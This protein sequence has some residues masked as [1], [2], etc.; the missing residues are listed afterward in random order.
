[1]EKSNYFHFVIKSNN[2]IFIAMLKPLSFWLICHFIT[3]PVSLCALWNVRLPSRHEYFMIEGPEIDGVL[4]LHIQH[5]CSD[6][7]IDSSSWL[8]SRTWS[9]NMLLI[10]IFHLDVLHVLWCRPRLSISLISS[11]DLLPT[12][13]ALQLIPAT[14]FL[15]IGALGR[16]IVG[17]EGRGR[18]RPHHDCHCRLR[19]RRVWRPA[20]Y[21]NK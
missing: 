14:W 8:L 18:I 7:Y 4:H 1:M 2:N 5:S 15:W 20:R 6:V 16:I 11:L 9:V 12:F 17:F 13:R 3:H 19:A 21:M 10:Q